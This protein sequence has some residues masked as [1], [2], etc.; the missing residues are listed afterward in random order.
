MPPPPPRP[1]QRRNKDLFDKAELRAPYDTDANTLSC[2]LVAALR[3]NLENTDPSRR[4]AV[5]PLPHAV[6]TDISLWQLQALVTPGM[7]ITHD[8]VDVW[9]WW[10]NTSQ[11]DHE[12]VWVPHLGWAHTLMAPPTDPRPTPSTGGQERAAPQPRANA[13][14]ISPYKGRQN[15]KGGRP[16]PATQP[17]GPGGAVFTKGRRRHAQDPGDAK[18]SLAPSP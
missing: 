16:Q 1:P 2:W 11:P 18:M 3:E 14:N 8:V 6:S 4:F 15:E 7:Q 10:F 12:G 13:L 5:V 9:I 17:Q